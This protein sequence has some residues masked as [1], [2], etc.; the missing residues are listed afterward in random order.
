MHIINSY[1]I[2]ISLIALRSGKL[3]C[4]STNLNIIWNVMQSIALAAVVSLGLFMFL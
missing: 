3:S 4:F 1:T 2:I